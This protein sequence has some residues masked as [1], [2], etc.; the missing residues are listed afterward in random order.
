MFFISID[1]IVDILIS[2]STFPRLPCIICSDERISET[3]KM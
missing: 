1:S 2:Y 3:L